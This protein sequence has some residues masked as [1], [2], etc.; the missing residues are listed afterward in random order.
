MT[1]KSVSAL[2][3]L[4]CPVHLFA[5]AQS[6]TVVGTVT[7][8]GGAVVPAAVVTLI[9]E[10][11]QFTRTATANMNAQYVATSFP[12]GQLTLRVEHPG[13]QRLVRTGVELTAAD[14]LTVDLQITVGS[15]QET[16]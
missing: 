15:V 7:D 10:R 1:T 6:G 5:Q 12:T 11:T 2:L 9:N 8:Q 13:F 3:F 16:V 4:V 14:T